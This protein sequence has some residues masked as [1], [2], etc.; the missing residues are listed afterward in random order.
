MET[1]LH[2]RHSWGDGRLR[3]QSAASTSVGLSPL[4]SRSNL[5]PAKNE[6][7]LSMFT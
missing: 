4:V 2:F 6:K 1:G 7:K 3:G 5:K